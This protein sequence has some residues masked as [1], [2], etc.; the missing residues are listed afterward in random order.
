MAESSTSAHLQSMARAQ[1][2]SMSP[3]RSVSRCNFIKAA[4]QNPQ[5]GNHNTE[6]SQRT[7]RQTQILKQEE[8][9]V[10]EVRDLRALAWNDVRL[11]SASSTDSCSN[12]SVF[13]SFVIFQYCD[14]RTLW[15]CFQAEGLDSGGQGCWFHTEQFRGAARAGDF[16]V[17]L[18]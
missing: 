1:R 5:K 7:Q 4:T 2:S 6:R 13:V 8:R 17:G 18:F 9:E 14:L 12:L 15:L 11:T 3:P 16:A 10:A